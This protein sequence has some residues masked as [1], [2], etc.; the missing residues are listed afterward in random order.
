V[1]VPVLTE[2]FRRVLA[3]QL[4]FWRPSQPLE[5]IVL[6]HPV[7]NISAA[8]LDQRAADLVEAIVALLPPGPSESDAP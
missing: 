1:A 4:S 5:P 8:A 6:E 7:Q 2:P 3:R